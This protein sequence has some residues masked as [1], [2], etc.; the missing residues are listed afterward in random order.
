MRLCKTSGPEFLPYITITRFLG[1]L[2]VVPV[3]RTTLCANQEYLLD[4]L[5][6]EFWY[7]FRFLKQV[8]V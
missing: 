7:Q 1:E 8:N 4:S 2:K 3:I 6:F 5:H